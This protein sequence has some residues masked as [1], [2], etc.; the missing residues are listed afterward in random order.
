MFDSIVLE[1]WYSVKEVAALLGFGEDT[2][3]RLTNRGLLQ[4]FSLPVISPHRKRSYESRRIQGAEI[5][6]FIKNHMNRN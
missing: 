5:I 6:R 2:V 4:A 3:I 1:K